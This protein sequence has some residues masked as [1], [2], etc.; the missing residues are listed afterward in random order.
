MYT[1]GIKFDE[2]DDEMDGSGMSKTPLYLGYLDSGTRNSRKQ[3]ADGSDLLNILENHNRG[4]TI[5]EIMEIMGLGKSMVMHAINKC[6]AL[7]KH[8]PIWGRPSYFPVKGE[9]NHHLDDVC[10]ACSTGSVTECYCDE[11]VGGRLGWCAMYTHFAFED[12]GG[13]PDNP[14]FDYLFAEMMEIC[15]GNEM[16]ASQAVDILMMHDYDEPWTLETAN[17]LAVIAK[18]AKE[19][20]GA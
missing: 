19:K 15:C 1:Y 18:I 10:S 6:C 11:C 12:F 20:D 2:G 16:W 13:V 5:S 17:A 9:G 3:M 4:L 7:H 14:V 8:E